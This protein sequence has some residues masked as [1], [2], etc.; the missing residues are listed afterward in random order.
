MI[1]EEK[2]GQGLPLVVRGG[3]WI[4]S[5]AIPSHFI[6]GGCP[7][8]KTLTHLVPSSPGSQNVCNRSFRW[9][10]ATVTEN[11]NH[12]RIIIIILESRTD[13][14]FAKSSYFDRITISFISKI[15]YIIIEQKSFVWWRI[16]QKC[17]LSS[18][19]TVCF[20]NTE[21]QWPCKQ[22]QVMQFNCNQCVEFQPS[23]DSLSVRDNYNYSNFLCVTS[24]LKILNHGLN[25]LIPCSRSVL[26]F[27]TIWM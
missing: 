6:G 4:S 3:F 21:K 11:V 22:K 8:S 10:Y 25:P 1:F 27:C 23:G 13:L 7:P 17:L 9:G 12:I 26:C 16:R 5:S 18:A 20:R 19:G 24:Q 14:L 15:T 2:R